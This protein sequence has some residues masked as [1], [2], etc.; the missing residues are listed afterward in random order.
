MGRINNRIFYVGLF[1][2]GVI[3]VIGIIWVNSKS[4]SEEEYNFPSPK[5][6]VEQYFNSWNNKDYPNMYSLFSDGFKKIEPTAKNLTSFR[7]YVNS[8][9]INKIKVNGIEERNNNG[10]NAEV[11]YN[12][13]FFLNTG[14]RITYKDTFTLKFRTGDIIQGW[15]LIHPYGNNID[16]T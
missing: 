1:I 8:Q 16:T 6:V 14:E 11:D 5:K 12:V 4:P 15:K 9:G 10:K 7:D 3:L 2:L 13:V